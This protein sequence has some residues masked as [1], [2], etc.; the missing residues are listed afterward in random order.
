M[1]TA[2]YELARTSVTT[3]EET[4]WGYTY[5]YEFL[6]AFATQRKA[7]VSFVMSAHPLGTAGLPLDGFT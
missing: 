5:A 2:Q 1:F 7:T 6:G 3:C 4:V